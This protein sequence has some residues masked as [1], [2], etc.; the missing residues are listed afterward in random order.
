MLLGKVFSQLAAR[1]PKDSDLRCDHDIM[2]IPGEDDA[3]ERF[4][5]A[6]AIGV[7]GIEKRDAKLARATDG[8]QRLIV[9]GLPPSERRAGSLSG[10]ANS[11]ATEA[12]DADSDSSSAEIAVLHQR[13]TCFTSSISLNE[14]RKLSV[15]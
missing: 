10:A 8:R 5:A 13:R 6:E 1:G 12:D 4:A 14:R 15:L 9:E 3:Q 2:P 7:G 11:P